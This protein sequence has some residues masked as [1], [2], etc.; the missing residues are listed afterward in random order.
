MLTFQGKIVKGYNINTKM[1]NKLLKK[2]HKG[3]KMPEKILTVEELDALEHYKIIADEKDLRWF[4]DHC[5]HPLKRNE[6][7]AFCL[8]SRHKKLTDEERKG[9]G[10]GRSEM[11]DPTVVFADAEGN[12]TYERWKKGIRAYECHKETFTTREGLPFPAKTLVCYFHL[13]PCD[14]LNV[15]SDLKK[16]INIHEQELIDSAIKDIDRANEIANISVDLQ[17][18]FADKDK[19]EQNL[20]EFKDTFQKRA[21]ALELRTKESGTSQSLYKMCKSLS[22]MKRLQ[23]DNVGTKY[24]VDFDMDIKKEFRGTKSEEELIKLWSKYCHQKLTKGKF[25]FVKT[26]GGIHTMVDKNEKNE[27]HFNPNWFIDEFLHFVST[28]LEVPEGAVTKDAKPYTN[29]FVNGKQKNYTFSD[30]AR[31]NV[32]AKKGES[33]LWSNW[34]QLKDQNNNDKLYYTPS[35]YIDELVYNMNAMAPV[36]G[37]YQYGNVVRVLNKKDFD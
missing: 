16:Y 5:V 19:V 8:S 24:W 36:P 11:M 32:L 37:T 26:G 18:V 3:F 28:S 34:I 31:D 7:Y 30:L 4:Y 15:I 25:V 1:M 13:N 6:A 22:K 14:E 17:N 21:K 33:N 9:T 35:F 10:L 20:K 23:F 12:T 27:I 2:L 29:S